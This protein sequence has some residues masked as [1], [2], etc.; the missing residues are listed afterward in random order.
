MSDLRSSWSRLGF[1][2]G[3][4]IAASP[5]NLE[6]ILLT[7]LQQVRKEPRLF[8]GAATWLHEY[9]FLVDGHE[10]IRRLEMATSPP[11]SALLAAL[12]TASSSPH[13]K[14][15]LSRC[16]AL[17]EEEILFEVLGQKE[18]LRAKVTAAA[19]PGIRRWGLLVDDLE[20]KPNSLRP[21]S[22]VLRMN[23]E[24]RIRA[25]LGANL[26]AALLY[27]LLTGSSPSSLSSLARELGRSYPAVHSAIGA[28][29]TAGLIQCETSG[30]SIHVR[31]PSDIK[32]WLSR[33]PATLAPKNRRDSAA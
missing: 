9:G 18:V 17:P 12:V 25:L 28:L 32:A 33:Y 27:R 19:I 1:S 15:L 16:E 13:L 31:V 26:R 14:G 11:A 6:G 20:L 30:R 7:S 4:E 3:G 23:P 5:P 2:F 10:L 22:W 8:L 29:R 24:L 21:S